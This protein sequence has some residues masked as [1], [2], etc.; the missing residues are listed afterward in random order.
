MDA[1]LVTGGVGLVSRGDG[2]RAVAALQLRG[3]AIRV[4]RVVLHRLLPAHGTSERVRRLKGR[5]RL[6]EVTCGG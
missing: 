4:R 3:V 5:G 6:G 1:A 2:A